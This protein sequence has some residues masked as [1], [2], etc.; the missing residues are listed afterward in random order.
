MDRRDFMKALLSAAAVAPLSG[1]GAKDAPTAVAAKGAQVSGKMKTV[2]MEERFG[3][4]ARS[5]IAVQSVGWDGAR[6]R[7]GLAAFSKKIVAELLADGEAT[8][9][10][11]EAY[12]ALGRDTSR[13]TL[14]GAFFDVTVHSD[15]DRIRATLDKAG[16]ALVFRQS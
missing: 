16:E 10:R 8:A 2:D 14:H 15:D 7:F 12:R 1:L 5:W 3:H 6:C 4:C 9:R 13:D 11:I